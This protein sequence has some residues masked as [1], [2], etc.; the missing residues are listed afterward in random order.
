M[1]SLLPNIT[2]LTSIIK[3]QCPFVSVCLSVCLSVVPPPFF[4]RHDRLTATKFGTHMR[5]DLGVIRTQHF[6]D[7]PHPSGDPGPGGILGG[8]KFKSPGNV[9]NCPENSIN[10]FNHHTTAF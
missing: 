10:K 7:P 9:M 1:V 8:Q 3:L 2:I 4:F 5:I 6:F